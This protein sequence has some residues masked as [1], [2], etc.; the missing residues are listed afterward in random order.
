MIRKIVP[1]L[2]VEQRTVETWSSSSDPLTERQIVT[3]DGGRRF[4]IGSGAGQDK[5]LGAQEVNYLYDA[6][7]KTIYRT[8]YYPVGASGTNGVAQGSL[9]ARARRTG[10]RLAGYADLRGPARVRREASGTGS[11]RR[12]SSTR[13]R[14]ADY[15]V[16]VGTGP[17]DSR[18]AH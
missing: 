15:S 2:P 14:T 9:Q 6:S 16:G 7:T 11:R 17:P 10:V 4:E 8:G 5:V 1:N 18:T 13:R 12:R 3:I